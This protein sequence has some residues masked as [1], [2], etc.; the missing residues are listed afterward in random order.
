V[1]F[2]PKAGRSA[3]LI[4]VFHY[5][6][7]APCNTPPNPQFTGAWNYKFNLG[8]YGIILVGEKIMAIATLGVSN[9]AG[10]CLHDP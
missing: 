8:K 5:L 3:Y 10:G 2:L 9:G 7:M 4:Q 1:Y 6:E